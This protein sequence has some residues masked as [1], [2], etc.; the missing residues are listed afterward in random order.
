MQPETINFCKIL[1]CLL[2]IFGIVQAALWNN[3]YSFLA[4]GVGFGVLALIKASS[5]MN[6]E[7]LKEILMRFYLLLTFD[8]FTMAL[9]SLLPLPLFLRFAIPIILSQFAYQVY[10][11]KKAIP[12][13]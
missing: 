12:K 7:R 1:H 5:Q 6:S 11:L 4:C 8:H 2:F 10:S 9:H 3:L 13:L